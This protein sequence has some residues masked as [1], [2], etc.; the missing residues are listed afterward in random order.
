MAEHHKHENRDA[1]IAV[2]VGGVALVLIL[3]YMKGGAVGATNAEGEPLPALTSIQ[4][5]NANSYNYNVAPYNPDPGLSY[6][7]SALPANNIGGGCC[8]N[9]GP[10]N[11]QTYNNVNIAQFMTLLGFGTA[12][13]A[14]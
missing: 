9:C 7:R 5:P 1:M 12:G 6:G 14:A 8:D 11:G 3:L 2:A 13:G 4:P 10:Q